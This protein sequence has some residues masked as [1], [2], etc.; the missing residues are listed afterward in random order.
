VAPGFETRDMQLQGRCVAALQAAG[1]LRVVH[2]YVPPEAWSRRLLQRVV[3]SMATLPPPCPDGGDGTHNLTSPLQPSVALPASDATVDNAQASNGLTVAGSRSSEGL[4]LHQVFKAVGWLR[5]QPC[6]TTSALLAD[7]AIRCLPQSDLGTVSRLVARLPELAS[8][9]ATT[10]QRAALRHTMLTTML[11]LVT[12]QPAS[13]TDT[14][15]EQAGSQS[16]EPWQL[17]NWLYGITRWPGVSSARTSSAEQRMLRTLLP[18]LLHALPCPE[19]SLARCGGTDLVTI[20]VGL[21]H[22]HARAVPRRTTP[23]AQHLTAR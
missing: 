8:G 15:V 16:L 11:N 12:P 1:K 20:T 3:Q 17:A 10:A 18:L 14:A 7:L 21:A 23:S 9:L 2:G 4:R 13:G 22:L 5:L 6:P 19:T